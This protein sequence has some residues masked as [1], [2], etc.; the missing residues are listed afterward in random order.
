MAITDMAAA[1]IALNAERMRVRAEYIDQ[2]LDVSAEE[3]IKAYSKTAELEDQIYSDLEICL[4][5]P[6]VAEYVWLLIEEIFRQL[7]NMQ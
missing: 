7:N 6:E 5:D 4:M 2:I 3:I 1:F